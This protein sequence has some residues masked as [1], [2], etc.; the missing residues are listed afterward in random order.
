MVT[1]ITQA[2]NL[3]ELPLEDLIGS[4]RAHEVILQGD[5]PIKNEK[6]IALKNLNNL[7][8]T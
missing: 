3:N 4:L 8:K 5:K 2:K 6:M 7:K 1:A